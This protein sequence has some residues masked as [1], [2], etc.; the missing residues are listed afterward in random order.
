MT[1]PPAGSGRPAG[2]PSSAKPKPEKAGPVLEE[3]ATSKERVE[4]VGGAMVLQQTENIN[5]KNVA[6]PGTSII[7]SRSKCSQHIGPQC[8]K[9]SKPSLGSPQH[10]RNKASSRHPY[11]CANEPLG[12]PRAASLMATPA[13]PS[14]RRAAP[15]RLRPPREPRTRP[16]APSQSRRRRARAERAAAARGVRALL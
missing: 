15:R 5:A 6:R 1:L 14:L 16:A 3:Q 7:F 4:F 9:P 8:F 11:H 2:R 12:R 10:A 13:A